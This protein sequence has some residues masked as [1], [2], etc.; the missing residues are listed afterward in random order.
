[1]GHL[2]PFTLR[3]IQHAVQMR[4]RQFNVVILIL[5][6]PYFSRQDTAS[7]H[8]LE[9]VI[10]E[11]V[12]GF[13]VLGFTLINPQVPPRIRA[14]PPLLDELVLLLCGQLALAPLVA[15]IQDDA[16]FL[17]QALGVFECSLVQFC[18]HSCDVPSISVHGADPSVLPRW[19]AF[20]GLILKS[21]PLRLGA[22]DR[23]K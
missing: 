19:E 4:R 22:N 6:S 8:P 5:T 18:R 2:S 3:C 23:R 11:L 14:E 12:P 1:M 15:F 10:R 17:D 13:R 16:S 21:Q 9:V 7:A 20:V